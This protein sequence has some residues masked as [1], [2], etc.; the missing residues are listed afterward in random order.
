MDRQDMIRKM[1]GFVKETMNK[2]GET[3]FGAPQFIIRGQLAAFMG[4]K[5]PHKIDWIL[6]GL[7][8]TVDGKMYY[9]PD[10]VDAIRRGSEIA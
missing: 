2:G 5:D 1:S 4:K 6:S 9:I 10:V 3:V 8:R 7:E